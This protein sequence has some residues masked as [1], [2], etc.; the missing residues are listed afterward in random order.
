MKKTRETAVYPENY[1]RDYVIH[2]LV[3]ELGELLETVRENDPGPSEISLPMT[4]QPQTEEICKE[5]G[6][7]TWYLARLA[8][9]FDI[10]LDE[11]WRP[12]E[13]RREYARGERLVLDSLLA[14]A[15]ING[16][17]KKS[18][19]D[20]SNRESGIKAEAQK[21]FKNLQS[22]AHHLGLYNLDVVLETNLDKLFDRKDR[23]KL[24]G[25]GDNR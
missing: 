7:C 4:S 14:A 24:H 23:G 22:A 8:D 18:V 3:D 10:D 19:R 2:G 1:E 21:I 11:L 5:M 9:R 13:N 25:D 16:H 20:D 12:S 6:D 17:Q 15:R